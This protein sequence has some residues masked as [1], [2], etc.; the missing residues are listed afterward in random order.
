M[1]DTPFP[2]GDLHPIRVAQRRIAEAFARGTSLPRSGSVPGVLSWV[3]P[4]AEAVGW[5]GTPRQI[6]EVMPHEA[7]VADVAS[8]RTVLLRL[9]IETERI[10]V[11]AKRIRDEYCPCIAV[12]R[13]PCVYI[14]TCG[15]VCASPSSPAPTKET[16][17]VPSVQLSAILL[18]CF[19]SPLRYMDT[20]NNAIAKNASGS[21]A[22]K[23]PPTI[24]H[25]FPTPM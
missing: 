19:F 23:I 22:E 5:R 13:V 20:A 14:F 3:V 21:N 6:A 11:P 4:I 9:G 16:I 17:A 10:D 12:T 8:F 25:T 1:T 18:G 2:D 15:N 24:S 7:P